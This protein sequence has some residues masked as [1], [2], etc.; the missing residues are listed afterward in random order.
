MLFKNFLAMIMV[1]VGLFSGTFYNLM[2]PYFCDMAYYYGLIA[3]LIFVM[4]AI[5][6]YYMPDKDSQEYY[7]KMLTE[8]L[9]REAK[10]EKIT[11]AHIVMEALKLANK[12]KKE[13][14]NDTLPRPK[15][16]GI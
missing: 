7:G 1:I 11:P 12:T 10:R 5:I 2:Y 4:T 16:R 13:V 6:L 3:S 8:H 9:N 14:K 15:G